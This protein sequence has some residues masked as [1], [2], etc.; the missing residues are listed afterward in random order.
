MTVPYSEW[1]SSARTEQKRAIKAK[2]VKER[3]DTIRR[4]DD[5]LEEEKESTVGGDGGCPL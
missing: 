4:V 5:I 3:T 2:K 1:G